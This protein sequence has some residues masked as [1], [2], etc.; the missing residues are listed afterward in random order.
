MI[1]VQGPNAR[2]KAAALLAP[3]QQ[4]AALE[5][6]PFFGAAFGSWFVART[7]YTG[8][9][10]FEVM[11]PAGECR[12]RLESAARPGRGARRAGRT[13]YLAP[14]GGHESLWQRHG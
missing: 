1:A 14:G 13:R 12:R 2:R 8:E 4:A 10:G 6:K 3:A 7:G 5:L 9:D 11:L